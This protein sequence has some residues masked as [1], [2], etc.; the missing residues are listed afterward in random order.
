MSTNE[1]NRKHYLE[2]LNKVFD[3]IDENIESEFNLDDLAK[4]SNFS[5]FHFSR[6]FN[7]MVGETPFEFIQKSCFAITS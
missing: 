4:T 5:K 2:R 6:V 3:Y 1:K 7:A